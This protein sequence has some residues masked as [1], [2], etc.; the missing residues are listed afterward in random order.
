MEGSRDKAL[1]IL[2]LKNGI[3]FLFLKAFCLYWIQL[4]PPYLQHWQFI[5]YIFSCFRLNTSTAT[6]AIR[7]ETRHQQERVYF[8]SSRRYE[9]LIVIHKTV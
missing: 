8:V 3:I 4:S 7:V 5:V 9:K 1:N 2:L 6:Q